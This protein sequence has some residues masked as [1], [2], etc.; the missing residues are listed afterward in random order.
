MG[1]GGGHPAKHHNIITP[2]F[3][4]RLGSKRYLG[5]KGDEGGCK[6]GVDVHL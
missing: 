1:K 6:Q 5:V 4:R 3:I 2:L